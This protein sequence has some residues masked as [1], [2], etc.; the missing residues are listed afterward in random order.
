MSI[1]ISIPIADVQ[2]NQHEVEKHNPTKTH[3]NAPLLQMI[4]ISE[5]YYLIQAFKHAAE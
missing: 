3:T 4:T 5:P 2:K 1:W